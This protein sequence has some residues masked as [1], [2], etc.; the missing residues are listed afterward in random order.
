MSMIIDRPWAIVYGPRCELGIGLL[1]GLGRTRE[2]AWY[3]S[4]VVAGS[5]SPFSLGSEIARLK[6][7]GMVARR[8]AVMTIDKPKRRKK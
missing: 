5:L 7:L 3:N 4:I 2:D 8:V 6:K 1:Y